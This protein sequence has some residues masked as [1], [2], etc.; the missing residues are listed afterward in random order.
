MEWVKVQFV[1]ADTKHLRWNDLLSRKLFKDRY[2]EVLCT[3]DRK[4]Y[5]SQF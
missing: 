5:R 3:C 2:R 1:M 4:F